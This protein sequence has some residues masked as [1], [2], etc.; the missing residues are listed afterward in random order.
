MAL[1]VSNIMK[2]VFSVK[3]TFYNKYLVEDGN[4]NT[5]KLD[6]LE[7]SLLRIQRRFWSSKKKKMMGK[8]RKFRIDKD[9]NRSQLTFN[10]AVND[11]KSIA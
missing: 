9:T 1:I 5:F 7:F 11:E 2:W 6:D 10:R 4:Q 8:K 3:K